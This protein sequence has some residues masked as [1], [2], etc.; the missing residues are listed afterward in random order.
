MPLLSFQ[1]KPRI[2]AQH[3]SIYDNLIYFCPSVKRSAFLIIW[4]VTEKCQNNTWLF[5][6]FNKIDLYNIGNELCCR[7]KI[8]HSDGFLQCCGGNTYNVSHQECCQGNGASKAIPKEA[9]M[10]CCRGTASIFPSFNFGVIS[11]M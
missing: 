9:E 7:N 6:A 3:S 2:F 10:L 4:S 5:F 1:I 11:V 8:F